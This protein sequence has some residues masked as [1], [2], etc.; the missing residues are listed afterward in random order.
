MIHEG[1]KTRIRPIFA[2]LVALI[3]LSPLGLNLL[4]GPHGGSGELRRSR[5]LQTAA[6]RSASFP[7][8]WRT[9]SGSMPSLPTTP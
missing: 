7:L 8:G 5:R 2:V 4:Q 3:C 6:K 9:D 1:A